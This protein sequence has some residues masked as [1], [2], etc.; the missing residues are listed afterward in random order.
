ML[1]FGAETA[2]RRIGVNLDDGIRVCVPTI[3]RRLEGCAVRLLDFRGERICGQAF[4]IDGAGLAEI[5]D[6]TLKATGSGTCAVQV[7]IAVPH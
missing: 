6:R 5:V 3:S 2:W 4:A 7:A 1:P